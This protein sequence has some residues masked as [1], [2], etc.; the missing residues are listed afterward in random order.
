MDRERSAQSCWTLFP[1]SI[2]IYKAQFWLENVQICSKTQEEYLN[3]FKWGHMG[4]QKPL[5]VCESL[6]LF[7]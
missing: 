5:S 4:L 3:G 6:L 1:F 2:I 7:Y